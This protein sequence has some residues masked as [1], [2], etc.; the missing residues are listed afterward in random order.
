MIFTLNKYY[1]C[2]K[3]KNNEVGGTCGSVGERKD[4]Y[5]VLV[6]KP[7]GN[8]PLARSGHTWEDNIKIC[9]EEIGCRRGLD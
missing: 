8:R 1:S 4:A 2:D 5:G 7:A 6:V 9:P 3:T